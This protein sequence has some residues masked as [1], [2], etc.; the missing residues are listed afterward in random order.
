MKKKRKKINFEIDDW[1]YLVPDA[2]RRIRD[3]VETLNGENE[4]LR[5]LPWREPRK[6]KWAG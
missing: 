3:V 6:L 4:I 1:D 5:D 2:V